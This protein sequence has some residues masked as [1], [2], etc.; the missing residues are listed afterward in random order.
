[1]F[2]AE[3]TEWRVELG[4]EKSGGRAELTSLSITPIA[5]PER[6]E[7]PPILTATTLRR[8]PLGQLVNE[9]RAF[10]RRI[11]R[12]AVRAGVADDN[13]PRPGR[14]T[15]WTRERLADVARVYRAAWESGQNPTVAVYDHGRR[16]DAAYRTNSMSMA[17]KAVASARRRGLLPKTSQGRVRGNV[18]DVEEYD[19][20]EYVS[21][22]EVTEAMQRAAPGG[23]QKVSDLTLPRE[24]PASSERAGFELSP[25]V[26]SSGP[27]RG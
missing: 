27:K 20:L 2:V 22:D 7:E 21:T 3:W 17:A 8:L 11:N 10:R 5:H 4:F 18:V 25:Q 14:P 15:Y 1:M 23:A 26:L 9:W 12:E 13:T 24:V 19:T 6:E 16:R